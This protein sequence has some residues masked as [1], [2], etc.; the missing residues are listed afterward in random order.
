MSDTIAHVEQL[1]TLSKAKGFLGREF[2]TWLWYVAE[3]SKETLTFEVPGREDGLE[4]DIW[5]DDRIVLEATGNQS[6]WRTTTTRRARTR[7]GL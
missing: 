2:L 4:L 1:T 7:L 6:Q 3:T 5:V